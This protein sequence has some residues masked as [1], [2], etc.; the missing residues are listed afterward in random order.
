MTA[1]VLLVG[2]PGEFEPEDDDDGDDD[3]DGDEDDG[4][5]IIFGLRLGLLVV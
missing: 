5:L 4:E 1:A 3:G 2:K